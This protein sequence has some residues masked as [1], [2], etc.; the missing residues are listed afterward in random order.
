MGWVVMEEFEV[1]PWNKNLET[2]IEVIDDQH[3]QLVILINRLAAHLADKSSE[4]T[5]KDV[6]GELAAYVDYH[7]QTEEQI[8]R[9]FFVADPWFDAHQ[10]VHEGFIEKVTAWTHSSQNTKSLDEIISELL[11]FLTHWLAYHIL[12]SDR[13]MAKVVVSLQ[14]GLEMEAAKKQADLEM[15]GAMKVLIDTVLGMYDSLS[16]RTLELLRERTERRRAEEALRA[17]EE[18]WQFVLDGARDGVWDW[19]IA[20]GDVYRSTESNFILGLLTPGAADGAG[21]I[22]PDDLDRVRVALQ[23]HLEGRSD[24]FVNEHRVVLPSGLWSWVLT[25][26][27]VTARDA[28][29]RALRMIGTHSDVTERELAVMF[30]QNTNEGMVVIDRGDRIVAVNPAFRRISGFE[31]AELLGRQIGDLYTAENAPV[32]LDL[33]HRSLA[34]TGFWSGEIW[35]AHRDGESAPVFLEFSTVPNPD[36]SPNYRIGL[37]GDLSDQKLRDETIWR[38]TNFDVLTGLPNRYMMADRLNQYLAPLSPYGERRVALLLLDL[39]RLRDINTVYGRHGGDALILQLSERISQRLGDNGILGRLGGDEF[40]LVLP[41]IED[42]QQLDQFA[43]EVLQQFESSFALN[44]EALFITGSIGIALAPDDGKDSETL[45]R[46]AEQ[47]MYQAKDKGSNRYAYYADFMQQAAQ[48]RT[49]LANELRH[50]LAAGQLFVHYQPIVD[51][52]TQQIVKAEALLRWQHPENGAISPASFIPIAE[53]CG[54]IN[55]IGN[56][57]FR[58]AVTQAAR[59]RRIVPDFQIGINVSPVQFRDN[60]GQVSDDPHGWF[61]YLTKQGLPG[62]MVVIEVTEGVMLVDQPRVLERMLAMHQRGLGISLDDFG[63]GYSSLSYLQR[64]PIDSIKIDRSFVMHLEE[65]SSQLALCEAMIVMAHKLGIAVVAEGIETEEQNRLLAAAG[66]DYGQG[67][68]YSKAVDHE[69]FSGLLAGL[70][71]A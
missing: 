57:V 38:Q 22:H 47:A 63:T 69:V 35:L 65:G 32:L 33:L 45:F 5:L 40:A 59:W 71:K 17:S 54:L 2:G 24:A 8:W 61:D 49:R 68:L 34:E 15:S 25:R 50:A 51:L 67:F 70:V 23:N 52:R 21:K 27:K 4:V 18:R 3:R 7:F 62:E 48:I 36:G 29:G 53:E 37:V 10:K 14:S 64:Y 30:F 1:F 66:C 60:Y 28:N 43:Q 16:A 55:E 39:D 46:H 11:G 56:W 44:D 20:N 9:S 19:N 31:P 58:E 26:G 12:D 13:R 42:M 41:G 6:F